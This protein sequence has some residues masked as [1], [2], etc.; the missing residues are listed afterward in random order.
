MAHV[1]SQ[2][3]NAVVSALSGVSATV[4]ATRYYPTDVEELPRVHVFTVSERMDSAYASLSTQG[5]VVSVV[6]ECIAT[7]AETTLD[8]TLDALCVE[9]EEALES[10]K[11]GGLALT[12]MLTTT[13]I[14]FDTD[15]RKPV[16]SALL[17][18]D[19]V[20]RTIRGDVETAV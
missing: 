17:T 7:G 13:D 9:V 10:S 12:T 6:V 16:G 2:I 4:K 8:D 18:F 20:Y 1:R 15:S 14:K 19:V 5:R 11:L 3:R